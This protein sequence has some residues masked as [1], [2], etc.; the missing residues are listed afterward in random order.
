MVND[1]LPN[2]SIIEAF[3]GHQAVEL[4]KNE[5]PDLIFMDIQMPEMNGY[6][7]SLAIRSLEKNK[8]TPIIALTAGT[9]KDEKERC[10]EAGM[11]DYITKPYVTASIMTVINKWL[12]IDSGKYLANWEI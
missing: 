5:Q 4:Y 10:L 1:I 11:D 2:A 7:A 9:L 12:I 8:K 6:E 3:D